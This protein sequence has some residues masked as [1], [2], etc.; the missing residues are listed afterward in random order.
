METNTWHPIETVPVNSNGV[1]L[2]RNGE[3]LVGMRY[4]DLGGGN[5]FFE[6]IR[7]GYCC[8]RDATHWMPSHPSPKR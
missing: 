3:R 4:V 5:T 7:A 6:A 8:V 2:L 1:D